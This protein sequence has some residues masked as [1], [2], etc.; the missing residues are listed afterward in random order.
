MV[1]VLMKRPLESFAGLPG[2]QLGGVLHHGDHR[3]GRK[4]RA[5][6]AASTAAWLV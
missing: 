5:L 4:R 3:A 1:L 2:H 6:S